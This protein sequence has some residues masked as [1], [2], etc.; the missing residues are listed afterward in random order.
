[1]I[2]KHYGNEIVS[3]SSRKDVILCYRHR[4][5][6]HS[7]ETPVLMNSMNMDIWVVGTSNQLFKRFLNWNK[8]L[9]KKKVVIGQN[10]LPIPFIL[11]LAS[12]SAVLYQYIM[13]S[14]WG[15]LAKKHTPKLKNTPASWKWFSIFF[16]VKVLETFKISCNCQ[17][18][19][20]QSLKRRAISKI[21][22]ST[23]F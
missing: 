11:R 3:N 8:M 4:E 12:D 14:I 20:Y 16:K 18:K 21:I 17:I 15:L 13:F 9:K 23:I 5:K 10:S 7:N 22:P 1:M 19:T 2:L 6:I